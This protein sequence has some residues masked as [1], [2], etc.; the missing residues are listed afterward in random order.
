MVHNKEIM[1]FHVKIFP[2]GI[3]SNRDIFIHRQVRIATSQSN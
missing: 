1:C 3:L 2:L